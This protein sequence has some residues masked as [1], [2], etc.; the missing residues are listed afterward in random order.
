MTN[1]DDGLIK[2][3]NE[4]ESS[5]AFVTEGINK[6]SS[7]SAIPHG[8]VLRKYKHNIDFMLIKNP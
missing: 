7:S 1:Q 6:I 2:C 4:T 8:E 3:C 5:Q